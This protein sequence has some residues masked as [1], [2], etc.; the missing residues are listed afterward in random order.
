MRLTGK[1]AIV[2][3]AASGIGA[4]SARMFAAE[5]ARVVVADINDVGGK[6]TVLE[7]AA[8][9]GEALFVHADVSRAVDIERLIKTATDQ[10]PRIDILF[11][12]AGIFMKNTAVEDV[13]ELLWDR[14]YNVNV[15][16][17]FMGAKLA[18]PVMKRSGG[19]VI[20]NTA[21]MTALGPSRGYS[22][23]ASSK[24]AV[25]TLTKVLAA[26]LAPHNIRV[27]CIAPKL[28][29]TPMVKD[30]MDE[31]RRI[32]RTSSDP[33]ARPATP[34]EIAGAALFLASDEAAMVSG[35]CLE[36]SG[37]QIM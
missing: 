8:M 32:P 23:Y 12:V 1:V 5:G 10:F 22:A 30:Q 6:Q 33:M 35:I 31:I 28:T 11:N 2:T 7:I 27:N 21:S 17:V 20:I 18:V 4:A 26:E 14:I 37:G 24:G 19:G 36:V 3:G 13:D 16:S 29:D 9:N 25:I 15:K 34:D